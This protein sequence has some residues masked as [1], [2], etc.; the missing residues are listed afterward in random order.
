M[1]EIRQIEPTKSNLKAF[2]KFP[3]DTLYNGNPY[4]V[5][6]L[7]SDVVGTLIRSVIPAFDFCESAYFM[8]Y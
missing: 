6:D 5:P 3:I 7:I 2:A 4:Y 8:A 1:I